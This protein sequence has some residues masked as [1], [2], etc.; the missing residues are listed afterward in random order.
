MATLSIKSDQEIKELLDEYGI[1][2]GPIVDSTRPL[3]E[4]KLREAMAKDKKVT[5]SSTDKT[6]KPS[7]DKTFYRE[8]EE[9][10]TY[11]TYRTPVRSEG[12][13]GDGKPYMRSRPDY[14]GRDFVDDE[15]Y[16]KS[17]PEYSSGRHYVDDK[18]YSK[19][20]PEYSSGRDYVAEP[21]IYNTPSMSSYSSY[22]KPSSVGRPAAVAGVKQGSPASSG[23]LI[24]LWVQFLVF[25]VVAGFLYFVFTNMESAE[26]NPFNRIQ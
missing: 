1:K 18:P 15:S 22:S 13:S 12:P 4:K 5:K 14:S 16:S 8:E 24:P 10:V 20:R 3:Y 17:H 19:P 7:T 9:E 6:T 11:V 2:H 25:L 26:T 21:H 23:R